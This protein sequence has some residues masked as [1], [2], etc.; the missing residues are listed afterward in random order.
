MSFDELLRRAYVRVFNQTLSGLEMSR[1]WVLGLVALIGRAGCAGSGQ[2]V[3][4]LVHANE[5]S[6]ITRL[7][8]GA[9]VDFTWNNVFIVSIWTSEPDSLMPS[10]REIL[11][12]NP[13][14]LQTL[15]APF[16]LEVS[17]QK[18]LEFNGVWIVMLL[19]IFTA[20]CACGGGLVMQCFNAR[21][22]IYRRCSI[23][24]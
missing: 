16:T 20:G 15:I 22:A 1:A 7:F 12:A 10:V 18:W 23:K 21:R 2:V 24:I 17:T 6:D 11:N 4:F 8:P 14:V 19:L 9:N 5:Q 13:N 3:Q